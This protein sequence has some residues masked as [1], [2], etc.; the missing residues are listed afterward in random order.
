IANL[1]SK[2]W[3]LQGVQSVTLIPQPKRYH[4]N[5]EYESVDGISMFHRGGTTSYGTWGTGFDN[6]PEMRSQALFTNWRNSP[7]INDYIPARYQHLDK[8]KTFPYM[9]IEATTW[10]G[11][12]LVIKP[13]SWNDAN[14]TI[15]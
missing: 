12:A 10:T 15:L 4:P 6:H 2:P 3:V 11:N 14:A 5:F 1:A 8:L 7:A 13:E 9:M